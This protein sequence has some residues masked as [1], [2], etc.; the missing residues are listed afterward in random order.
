MAYLD[1][2]C[3]RQS[4]MIFSLKD[5][6]V[7]VNLLRIQ[8]HLVGTFK[9]M[10]CISNVSTAKSSTVNKNALYVSEPVSHDCSTI[11]KCEFMKKDL[12]A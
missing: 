4:L 7:R 10:F 3:N 5:F 2:H 12:L 6:P 9:K 11:F 1:G 8:F